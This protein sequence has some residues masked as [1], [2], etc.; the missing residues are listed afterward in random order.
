MKFTINVQWDD[1]AHVWYVQDSDVP[2]LVAEAPTVEALQSLLSVRVP[3]LLELN[4]PELLE[5]RAPQSS[6][7][8]V[9][10]RRLDVAAAC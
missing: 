9:T 5:S 2:G 8:I 10:H 7:E 4:M 1:E 6:Y 3:E